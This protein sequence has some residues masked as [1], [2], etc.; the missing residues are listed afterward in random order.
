[1]R[2]T[3]S[4]KIV[5]VGFP[6]IQD[7]ERLGGRAEGDERENDR[8]GERGSDRRS[9]SPDQSRQLSLSRSHC[10]TCWLVWLRWSSLEYFASSARE[11]AAS[12][13]RLTASRTRDQNSSRMMMFGSSQGFTVAHSS[14]D[15]FGPPLVLD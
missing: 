11:G 10:G 4:A 8:D 3:S 12:A 14:R 2:E 7:V 15:G 1:R 13:V 9:A 5:P 6:P